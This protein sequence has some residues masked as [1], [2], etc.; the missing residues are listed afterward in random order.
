M[1]VDIDVSTTV[2]LSFDRIEHS[3]DKMRYIKNEVFFTYM[4]DADQRFN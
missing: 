3:L 2:T 1:I 4:K